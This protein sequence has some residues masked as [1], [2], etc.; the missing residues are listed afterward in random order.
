MYIH[1]A[2]TP[3]VRKESFEELK[4][5]HFAIK[6]K[7]KAMRNMANDRV[8]ALVA[9]HFSVPVGRVRLVSGHRSPSKLFSVDIPIRL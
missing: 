3:G 5:D 8:R 4:P 7:E 9:K 2:V 1:V 6:V